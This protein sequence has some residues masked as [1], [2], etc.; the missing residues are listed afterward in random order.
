MTQLKRRLGFW[1]LTCYGLGTTLGAGIYVLI[2]EVAARAG[3]LT[4]ISFLIAGLLALPSA[5][6]FAE[7]A[8]RYPK[9]AGEAVYI[10]QAFQSNGLA[11][12][13][14][15]LVATSGIVSAATMINGFMNYLQD[16]FVSDANM[17]RVALTLSLG[18]LAAWGIKQSVGFAAIITVLE[19]GALL[20]ISGFGAT[21][22]IENPNAQ[23]LPLDPIAVFAVFGGALLAF[24]AFI[25]FED[26]VNVAEE[27][28]DIKTNMPRAIITT[29][30]V[31]TGLYILV[32]WVAVSAIPSTELSQSK[33]P[34]AHLFSRSSGFSSAPIS[35]IALLA[36][37]NGALV[38]I[39]MASRVFYGMA[40]QN[41]LPKALSHV[42]K[43][44]GTPVRAT[45]IITGLTGFFAL[46]LPLAE[47][48]ALTSTLILS[49]FALV[50][51]S[52]V[53]IKLKSEPIQGFQ[54]PIW[55]PLTGTAASGAFVML[56]I[57]Q[58]LELY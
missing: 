49:V 31:T 7:L 39:I 13:V 41:W 30:I 5:L 18:T 19:A 38:Q 56:R 51:L 52:L 20:V 55:V 34:L 21:L 28:I 36:I 24:Y 46:A 15:V 27:V 29:L 53:R 17:T 37:I 16:F 50:N 2:G 47:L 26:M 45:V 42:N 22:I 3:Y 12:V 11:F 8:S 10:K 58:V 6:S 1:L 23:S 44:T 48:A 9:S 54:I 35:L 43:R 14:G 4:P 25:G 40:A 57:V 32:S 33:A